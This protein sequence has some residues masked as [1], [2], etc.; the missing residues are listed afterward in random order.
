VILSPGTEPC[1]SPLID[2]DFGAV[3][4]KVQ[5]DFVESRGIRRAKQ[6]EWME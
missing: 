5:R 3:N 1:S 6:C 2:C 4:G